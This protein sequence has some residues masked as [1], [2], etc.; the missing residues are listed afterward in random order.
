MRATATERPAHRGA[1]RSTSSRTDTFE[2]D[3]PAAPGQRLAGV[4]AR[5]RRRAR[6]PREFPLVGARL[7]ITG[8]VPRGAGLSSSAALE[9]ALCAGAPGPRRRG[10]PAT[11]ATWRGSARGPRTTGS[12]LGPACS[13]SSRASS[14]GADA[15]L[16]IDFR[17]LEIEPVALAT[18]RLAAGDARLGR[19]PRQRRLRLQPAPRRV[20]A[21]LRG[22]RGRS[23]RD[24][25]PSML[26]A[27]DSPAGRAGT[28]RDRRERVASTRRSPRCAAATWRRSA[29][30]LNASHASLRDLYEVSTPAVEAT[31]ATLLAAG[32]AGARVVGGGFG[33]HV[34]A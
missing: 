34:L 23:L 17:S 27:L 18:R 19:A 22:A 14:A 1:R 10:S 9:V 13:T 24:A 2:A 16:R 21:G 3:A 29:G 6:A 20:R 7:E 30:L 33:G 15:A 32:A 11:G 5:R 28:A 25:E 8:T 12:A 31:V 26:G 4:R